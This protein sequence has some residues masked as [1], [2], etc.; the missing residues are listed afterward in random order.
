MSQDGGP[1]SSTDAYR[2]YETAARDV[3]QQL[4]VLRW[5]VVK[6][7]QA[8]V[9]SDPAMLRTHLDGERND[10]GKLEDAINRLE[11]ANGILEAAPPVSSSQGIQRPL[12]VPVLVV[13]VFIKGARELALIM[14][15]KLV[16]PVRSA[17]RVGGP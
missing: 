11:T 13:L 14:R 3:A 5:R 8:I 10:L 7:Q 1:R 2:D 6:L 12:V 17:G 4:G 16:P 9:A 15:E